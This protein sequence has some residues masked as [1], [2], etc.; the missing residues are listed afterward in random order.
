M[1]KST[2]NELSLY[3]TISG[4]LERVVILTPPK[5]GTMDISCKEAH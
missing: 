3:V 4:S 2:Y 1:T 5:S